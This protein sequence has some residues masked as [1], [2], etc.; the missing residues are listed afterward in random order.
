M[1]A[2][3]LHLTV[4]VAPVMRLYGQ[5]TPVGERVLAAADTAQLLAEILP[6]RL[7][8]RFADSGEADF[9]FSVEG[10]GRFRCNAYRQQGNTA[11]AIRVLPTSPPDLAALGLPAV[12]RELAV[13]PNGLVLI[14]GPTGSGKS[15]TL[16]AMVRLINETRQCHVIT[17]EDP[18]EY[19]HRHGKSIINQREIGSDSRSFAS[20]LR[21]ALRED[22][23]VIM[24]GELRDPETIAIAL[25][26]A[27]TG[28]LVLGTLH[29]SSAPG[30]VDRI[31]DS[32]PPHQ[33][34]QVRSQL[35]ATI[36]G[37]VAQHLLPRRDRR[38]MVVACEVLVGTVAVRALIR[39]GK[40]HQLV[41][42]IQTGG[43]HGMRRLDTSLA[44]LYERGLIS[45]EEYRRLTPNASG[46]PE[47]ESKST[48]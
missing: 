2:S 23:D 1:K 26:A 14:T 11:L 16:A 12:V 48:P 9:A 8:E 20:A 47:P 40:V 27:E 4:G 13:R 37:V 19:I 38:G 31:V 22:P 41:S 44:E 30:A 3:D 35:A 24:V 5:L 42:A 18:V 39:E 28:H 15:T 46:L 7:A 36:Q 43:A 45:E 29:T 33:Q 34:P 25:T 17:L 32:F 10:L 21:A 6:A